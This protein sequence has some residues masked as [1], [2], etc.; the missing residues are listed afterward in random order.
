MACNLT[1][2]ER[3]TLYYDSAEELHLISVV[4]FRFERGSVPN[5]VFS[6]SSFLGEETQRAIT[7]LKSF[8]SS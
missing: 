7:R 8:G 5:R 4:L 2:R 6:L 3:L 1:E